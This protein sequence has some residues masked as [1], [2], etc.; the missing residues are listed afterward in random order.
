MITTKN[1]NRYRDIARLLWKYGRSDLVKQMGLDEAV[2]EDQR[3]VMSEEDRAVANQLTDDLEAMGPTYVKL[4]QVL[5]GRPDL[6]PPAYVEALTRLQDRV[7]PFDGAEA[8]A[9]VE[10]EIGVRI[11]KAF[12]RFDVEP[13]A[14]ASL[15]Q[16]HRAALRDG[17]E[18][19]VKVQRPGIGPQIVEDFEVLGQIAAL[20]EQHTQWGERHRITQIVEELRTSV[21][22]ELD[23]AREAQNLWAMRESLQQFEKIYVPMPINDFCSRT[24]LTMEFVP[25][26]KITELSPLARMEMDG[27]AL[28]DELFKAYLHQVL[29]DGLF[30]ADPHPGNVFVTN[31][32]HL[33]LLDLGMVGRTTPGMQ[34]HLVKVLIAV[35]EGKAEQASDVIVRM[36]QTVNNF[37]RVAFERRVG[38]IISD[39][40]GQSLGQISVGRSLLAVT[41]TAAD[42]GVFVPSQLTLL[43]KTL[44]Q[45]DEVGKCL[46]P[47]FD[48][49]AAIRRHVTDLL[50]K[51]MRK[52]ST[53]GN[54]MT[55]VL[56]MKDFMS[57]LPVRL[58]RIM[59]A[60]GNRE[61]EIRVHT[62]EAGLVMEGLQKVANRITS[63][64]VLAAL[65]IGAALLMRVETSFQVLGYPGIAILCFLAATAGGVWLLANIFVQDRRSEERAPR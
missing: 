60:V 43:A 55:S 65:I 39:Q 53:T 4:G 28:A 3:K 20:L 48:P 38:Q 62:M 5:S 29:V 7:K 42:H 33:V 50:S 22:H 63:G 54:L 49:N 45:L 44:L 51:R 24:V 34:E 35:S 32:G 46:D 58:N 47:D 18:V 26:T 6:I 57:G 14:A 36:S 11:S 37:D 10:K 41:N 56:E 21:Q 9:I 19:V 52:Q 1:L 16:V 40:H 27:A 61:L 30:H 59:D 25:G 8:V 23:Y 2:L 13:M 17:R 64:L 15:G 12:S 31:D